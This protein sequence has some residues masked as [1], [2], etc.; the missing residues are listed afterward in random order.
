MTGVD[1]NNTHWKNARAASTPHCTFTYCTWY[2]EP[3]PHFPEER[4]CVVLMAKLVIVVLV[5]A[6]GCA[7]VCVPTS[8]A[9]GRGP[10]H[11]ATTTDSWESRFWE[12]VATN[13]EMVTTNTKNTELMT[14]L[15][16]KNTELFTKNTELMEDLYTTRGELREFKEQLVDLR[17]KEVTESQPTSL[18]DILETVLQSTTGGNAKI[19]INQWVAKKRSFVDNCKEDGALAPFLNK[20]Y[21]GLH[22]DEKRLRAALYDL[23]RKLSGKVHGNIAPQDAGF[24]FG[25]GAV[26]LTTKGLLTDEDVLLLF[27]FLKVGGYPVRIVHGPTPA[28]CPN[29]QANVPE[30]SWTLADESMTPG[31]RPR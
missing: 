19:F 10:Q 24:Y 23:C 12:V 11:L 7:F 28:N 18:R 9:R 15:F 27:F 4:T 22:S 16:T 30:E 31:P 26:T 1:Y 2:E 6:L 29:R 25:D 21:S 13:K 3:F 14:E 5:F 8:V 17:R 20:T